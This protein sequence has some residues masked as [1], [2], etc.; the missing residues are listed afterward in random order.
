MINGLLDVPGIEDYIRPSTRNE[1]FLGPPYDYKIPAFDATLWRYIDFTKLVS[2]LEDQTI[3]FAR[4]D[5]LGDPFE[6]A[7]SNVNHMVLESATTK[8]AVAWRMII[9]EAKLRRRFTL[10]N[11]WHTS[12]HESEAMWKLYSG[13]RYGLAVKTD[14]KTL[15]HSFTDRTP[16]LIAQVEYIPYETQMMPWTYLA[17]FFHK[18]LSFEYERE[19]R[20]IMAFRYPD[21]GKV[22][23]PSDICEVGL[24]FPIDPVDLIQEVVVSPY[25]E[26][27]TFDLVHA[28]CT[29][30]GVAAPVR[31]SSMVSG[32]AW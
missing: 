20:A 29:R 27:W 7:W 12:E 4:A 19:V 26:P 3:F 13:L 21:E 11:C 10:V 31:L 25:A 8:Q 28:V 1:S 23:Y 6:G 32:P 22:D 15:V 17:P 30:Y 9:D 14:F 16:D 18:R 24:S 5:K 2:F